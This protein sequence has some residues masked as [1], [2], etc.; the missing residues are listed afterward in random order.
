MNL[1][2]DVSGIKKKDNRDR[3]R[4]KLK[5]G[6]A[7]KCL[8]TVIKNLEAILKQSEDLVDWSTGRTHQVCTKT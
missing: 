3:K 8:P 5:F 4:E 7:A 1:P 6:T 2:Q